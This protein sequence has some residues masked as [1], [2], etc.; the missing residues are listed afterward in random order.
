MN[1]EPSVRPSPP[2]HR[3]WIPATTTILAVI[4]IALIQ[5]ERGA[6]ALARATPDR[7]QELGR[8]PALSSKSWNYPTLAGR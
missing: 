3:F 7:F 5:S 1:S 4:G 2:D 8:I 6:V